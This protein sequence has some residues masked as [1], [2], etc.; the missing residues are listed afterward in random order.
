[1]PLPPNGIKIIQYADDVSIYASGTDIKL[2]SQQ[3]HHFCQVNH[4]LLRRKGPGSIPGKYTVTLFTPDNYQHKIHPQVFIK[5][6][7][8]KLDKNPKLLCIVFDAMHSFT[9]QVN[10]TVIKAKKKVN[11]MKAL[12]GTTWGQDNETLL[13]VN[14]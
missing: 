4:R 6:K 3:I 5:N 9:S 7:L 14:L 11:V 13:Q 8:V 12:A 2:I 10:S 1:M